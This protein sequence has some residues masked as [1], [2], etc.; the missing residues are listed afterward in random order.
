LNRIDSA[1]QDWQRRHNGQVRQDKAGTLEE[2]EFSEDQ[3]MALKQNAQGVRR[4]SR[5][6]VAGVLR[7][8]EPPS[9]PRSI[10]DM[11]FLNG[12]SDDQTAL[13]GCALALMV[14]GTVMSLSYY[15]GRFFH[16]TQAAPEPNEPQTLKMPDPLALASK[17]L[18]AA[19]E[20]H[21]S[22]RAA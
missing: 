12:L 13:V 22:R 4:S 2:I 8:D 15:V 1:R 3:S 9:T 17:R 14:C 7:N 11:D 18:A 6:F 21:R 10:F 5:I 16:K 19:Q 20:T